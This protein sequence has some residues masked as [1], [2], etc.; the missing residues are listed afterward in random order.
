MLRFL[1]GPVKAV[2]NFV[3][4][5]LATT[6]IGLMVILLG[7][8]KFIVP[9]PAVQRQVSRLAN[10]WFR[11][12]AYAVSMMFRLTHRTNWEIVG[13]LP[14]N[15]HGWYMILC[16]HLSWLDIVV[17]MHLSRRQLPMPRFFLKQEL[18]WVPI[19]G[20]GCWVLDMP[21]MK[22][23]SK[24]KIRKKPELQGKDIATTRKKCQKFHYIPTTVVNF[25]EGTRF[26]P[27]KHRQKNSPY[28]YLLPPKAGGTSFTLQSMGDQFQEI[29]DIT[30]VYPHAKPGKSVVFEFLSGRM[31]DIYV[32][33]E[34]LPVEPE[35]IGD[36][37]NDTDFRQQFQ[38]WL[39]Q[40]WI[41]KDE[42]I[43][44]R[45]QQAAAQHAAEKRQT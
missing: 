13:E 2:I 4:G 45:H 14:D 41:R 30:L 9:V 17:L 34:R 40:R 10:A 33:I 5:A 37:F 11:L 1:P 16:N 31:T 22:R 26:T 28:Q 29:I 32:H 23:Y 24:E 18:F 3:W 43:R 36:Y 44:Q 7:L 42:L 20:L 39:N 19:I 21:F 12:W 25:C 27:K 6:F 8:I 38:H 15:R 35:L